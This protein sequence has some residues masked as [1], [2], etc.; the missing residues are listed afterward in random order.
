MVSNL[1]AANQ[2]ASAP[3]SAE[4]RRWIPF[5]YRLSILPI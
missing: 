5:N 2:T 1:G 3:N 4:T